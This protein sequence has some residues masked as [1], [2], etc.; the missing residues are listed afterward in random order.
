M[1]FPSA[2]LIHRTHHS[3]NIWLKKENNIMM[4][5]LLGRLLQQAAFKPSPHFITPPMMS[6]VMI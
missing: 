4:I 1:H 5:F 6:Q 2:V 3:A